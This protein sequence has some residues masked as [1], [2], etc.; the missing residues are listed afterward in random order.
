METIVCGNN[1]CKPSL[2]STGRFSSLGTCTLHCFTKWSAFAM[3]VDVSE[4]PFCDFRFVNIRIFQ[5]KTTR[6]SGWWWCWYCCWGWRGRMG[7]GG[8]GEEEGRRGREEEG[9]KMGKRQQSLLSFYQSFWG[10]DFGLA[11]WSLPGKL[12]TWCIGGK[13]VTF[14]RH[15][16]KQL[17]LLLLS[18]FSSVRL[19][20]TP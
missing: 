7:G 15:N 18:R 2:V 12:E 10:T 17:L 4:F 16:T 9:R 6:V 11:W 5:K 8:G 19:C 1:F 3:R 20:A 13:E 14:Q